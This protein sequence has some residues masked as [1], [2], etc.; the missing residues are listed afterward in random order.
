MN[1]DELQEVLSD[2]RETEVREII[3][4]GRKDERLSVSIANGERIP[5]GWRV[6]QDRGAMPGWVRLCYHPE[7]R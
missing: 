3:L 6:I 1:A 2:F 7:D 4:I 5:A